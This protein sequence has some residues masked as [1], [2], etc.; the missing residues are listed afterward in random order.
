MKEENLT[1]HYCHQ[2]TTSISVN[3]HVAHCQECDAYFHYEGQPIQLAR[4]Y[5]YFQIKDKRY[6]FCIRHDL[7]QAILRYL[8]MERGIDE[9]FQLS[10]IPH[11]WTPKN[12]ASRVAKLLAFI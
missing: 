8:G 10:H 6:E 2:E 3:S 11:S 12:I 9:M 4:T 5:I 7:N 1:C